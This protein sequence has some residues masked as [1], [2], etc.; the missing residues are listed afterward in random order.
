MAARLLLLTVLFGGY[1][2]AQPLTLDD[3]LDAVERSYPLLTAATQEQSIADAR[4]LSAQGAFDLK[5]K[6]KAE[7]EQLGFYRNRAVDAYLEQPIADFGAN[8]FGGYKR[9]QGNFGPWREDLLSL[10]GGEFR[11]GFSV[12]LWRGRAIDERRTELRLA[13]L[14]RQIAGAS[15]AKQRLTFN[16]EASKSY[17]QW[18]A[19]GQQL[20]IIRALLALA[21]TRNSAVEETVRE[22]QT[23]PIELTDNQR[24]I[25]KRQSEVVKAERYLQL[26]AIDMSLFYRDPNGDPVLATEDQLPLFPEPAA[27]GAAQFNEDL[28][29][30]LRIRPELDAFDAKREQLSAELRLA[31][32]QLAPSIDMVASYSRD[33]GEGSITKVGNEVK[34]SVVFELPFQRRKAKG[35]VAAQNAKLSQLASRFQ[36]A[37]NRITAQVQD[38]ASALDAAYRQLSLVRQEIEVA[39]LLE[40]GERDRFDL[41]DSTLFLVNLREQAT[42]DAQLRETSALAEFHKAQAEY[43]AAI[44][45]TR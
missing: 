37:R 42:A 45:R 23:A 35:K 8:I 36:F 4:V 6:S 21:T 17:W 9:G 27:L 7:T 33:S 26:A 12:P 2:A 43:R 29:T 22:G 3:V 40:Q 30:A 1:A 38:A 5:V 13:D 44:G 34:A 41:G 14:G 15:I 19:A 24:A 25:L 31:E 32:N 11:G 10:D 20:Q 28:A 16:K 18:V 39:R